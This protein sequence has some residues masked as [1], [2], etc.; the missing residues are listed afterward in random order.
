MDFVLNQE[1]HT[2]TS[3]LLNT[4]FNIIFPYTLGRQPSFVH[5]VFLANVGEKYQKNFGVNIL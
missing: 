3:Y 4:N 5:L 2:L 1:I